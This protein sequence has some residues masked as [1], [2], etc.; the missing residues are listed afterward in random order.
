MWRSY[1]LAVDLQRIISGLRRL[2]PLDF[3]SNNV[4]SDGRER[5]YELTDAVQRLPAPDAAIPEMF[6]VMERMP[7]VDLG[8]PGPLVHTLEAIAGYQPHLADSVRRQPSLLSVWMVNRILNTDIP[9]ERREFW[10]VLL[11][12]SADRSDTPEAVRKDV[13]RLIARQRA[14]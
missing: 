14:K 3:D 1:N 4:N 7:D 13:L 9:E 11:Q 12:D 6:G 10:M 8:S 5:L 2:S